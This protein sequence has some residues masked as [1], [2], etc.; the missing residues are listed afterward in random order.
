MQARSRL[1]AVHTELGYA[2]HELPMGEFEDLSRPRATIRLEADGVI[3]HFE[4]RKALRPSDEPEDPLGRKVLFICKERPKYAVHTLLAPQ[5]P[6][7]RWKAWLDRYEVWAEL[8]EVHPEFGHRDARGRRVQVKHHEPVSVE[9]R[10]GT[11]E[12]KDASTAFG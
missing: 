6:Q 9:V 5:V 12:A 8:V 11:L 7:E 1:S 2:Q 10:T 3:E 4:K